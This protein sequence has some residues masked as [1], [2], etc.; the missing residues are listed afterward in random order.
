[1]P[2]ASAGGIVTVVLDI[3]SVSRL[4]SPQ[5]Q[6]VGASPFA[7]THCAGRW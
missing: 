1:M 4:G 5:L 2:L 3:G 6:L 7:L